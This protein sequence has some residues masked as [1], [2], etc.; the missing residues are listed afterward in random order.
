MHRR[1]RGIIS[2]D[3]FD[4]MIEGRVHQKRAA[5]PDE[6]AE[7]IVFLCSEGAS[8]VTGSTLTADGGMALTL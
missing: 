3:A 1:I 2:D 4:A 7:T 6:I 5:H 8:Y